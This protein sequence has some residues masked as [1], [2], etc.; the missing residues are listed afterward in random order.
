MSYY[1]NIQ[2]AN[3][4]KVSNPTVTKWVQD[5]KENK[6][7][8]QMEIFK[9]RYRILDNPHNNA[10]LFRL[11][12]DG[13]KY[14]SGI[15]LKRVKASSQLQDTFKPSEIAEIYSDL[16]FKREI[17]FKHTYKNQG[18]EAW[19]KYFLS[20]KYQL[21]PIIEKLIHTS[22]S[23]IVSACNKSN[24]SIFDLG[25]GNAYP[26]KPIL[27]EF[28]QT[29]LLSSYTAVDISEE[30]NSIAKLNVTQWF[31]NLRTNSIA[32]DMDKNDISQY[33]Y[34]FGSNQSTNLI[35]Y[36]GH[37]IC[38]HTDTLSVLKKLRSSMTQYDIL[39]F[40][41][42]NSHPKNLGNLNYVKNEFA[43]LR[44]TWILKALGVDTELCKTLIEYDSDKNA[45][46]KYIVLDKN[47]EIELKIFDRIQILELE[48][49]D[50]IS[51]WQH[52]ILDNLSLLNLLK[53]AR[54]DFTILKQDEELRNNLIICKPV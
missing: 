53:E 5:A 51:V 21:R 45:K 40:T 49:G 44:H 41:Y 13:K 23:N 39:C 10:E 7:N 34:E 52:Y 50:Q 48:R 9:G 30:M 36:L 43:E 29:N 22:I 46:F 11:A 19:D 4:F 16:F 32:H 6:N 27:E 24:V 26:V 47:Y 2:I 1:K 35:L 33:I 12:E 17:Q 3:K 20:G 14:R 54:L 18:A 15:G 42:T 38:N 31:P 25:P 37:T 8:L 28:Y